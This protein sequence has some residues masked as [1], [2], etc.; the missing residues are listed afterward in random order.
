MA[1]KLFR[2]ANKNN[3]FWKTITLNIQFLK[4]ITQKPHKKA[5]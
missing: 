4:K 2:T 1:K 5:I 3:I